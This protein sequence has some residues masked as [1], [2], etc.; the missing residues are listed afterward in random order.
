MFSNARWMVD[1][2]FSSFLS[3]FSNVHL[4]NNISPSS[5]WMDDVSPVTAAVDF[6]TDH[7]FVGG[8]F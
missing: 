7:E 5:G 8:A 6:I 4:M 3:L 2:I 1:V